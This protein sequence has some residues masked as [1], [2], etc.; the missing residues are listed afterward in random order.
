MATDLLEGFIMNSHCNIC[1][2]TEV[3]T[4]SASGLG[5]GHSVHAQLKSGGY[6]GGSLTALVSLLLDD[7]VLRYMQCMY[8]CSVRSIA[9]LCTVSPLDEST[10]TCLDLTLLPLYYLSIHQVNCCV[11]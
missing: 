10:H 7:S 6:T 1:L 3:P 4:H 5:L 8:H 11:L 9:K 2:D